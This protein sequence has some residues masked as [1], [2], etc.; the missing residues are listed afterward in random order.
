MKL[1]LQSQLNLSPVTIRRDNRHYIIEEHVSGD[2][3]EMPAVCIDAIRLIEKEE[4]LEKIETELQ[5]KY[6]NEEVDMVA[7]SSQ[8]LELGLVK[9]IDGV[10]VEVKKRNQSPEGF[11]WIPSW[12]GSFFF[13][14]GTTLLYFAIIF[15]NIFLV[16]ANP[17]LLP[18]YGD[19][20]LFDAMMLN[21]LVFMGLSLCLILI[22]ESG[23]ILA[24]RAYDL[25]ARLEIGNRLLFVVFET[26][27]TP[28][29][30]LKPKQRNSLY[31]AGIWFDQVML[32]FAFAI[33]L[34]F[35]GGSE[36]LLG[37]LSLIVLD[38]FIKAIYQC[39]FYMKTDLYYVFENMTGCYNL[40]E[41]GKAYL[42]RWIPFLKKDATTETF[43][44]E[45]KIVRAYGIFYLCGVVLTVGLFTIYFIPQAF[46]AYSQV[47]PEL[48]DPGGN[49][50]FWD[51]VAFIGQT[52]LIG[53]LLCYSWMKK[54]RSRTNNL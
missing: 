20:F 9:E 17:A 25:P 35:P 12:L 13:N 27:L 54:R 50:Y 51:A 46:Y 22:H 8:L 48:F 5:Q 4:P 36:F 44:G 19:L 31:L 52:V 1:S 49:P 15:M 39:C 53:G 34:V 45:K 41:N 29:W 2:F 11:M 10:P 33:M 23:H 42:S 47:L 40:M 26:D 16:V 24:V 28:A 30:K 32:F 37:L 14:K 43:E 7:F 21:V 3:F 18:S 6:P 38:L